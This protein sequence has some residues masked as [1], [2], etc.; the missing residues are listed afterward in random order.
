MKILGYR[1]KRLAVVE[2]GDNQIRMK[3]YSLQGERWSR[4]N[5]TWNLRHMD[6]TTHD[7]GVE[8]VDRLDR[9]P[10][11]RVLTDALHMWAKRTALTFIEAHPDDKT[12]DLQGLK[13][14]LHD[15]NSISANI[16]HLPYLLQYYLLLNLFQCN[17]IMVI[18]M[19]DIHLMVP[20]L[21]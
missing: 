19:T 16:A 10:V 15:S 5:L 2:N 3:R 11:R 14:I 1:N 6:K 17:S 20:D 4:T 9:G 18:M 8:G 21:F 7:N 13:Y 12:A